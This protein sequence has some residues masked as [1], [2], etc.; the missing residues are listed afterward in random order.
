MWD[1]QQYLKFA[2]ERSRPFFDLIARV[3]LDHPDFLADLDERLEIAYPARGGV[4]V[5]PFP[6]LFFVAAKPE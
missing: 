4:T 5:L 1:A 3:R 2:E 6:R